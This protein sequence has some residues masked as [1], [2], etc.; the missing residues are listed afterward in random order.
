VGRSFSA[1]PEVVVRHAALWIN[2]HSGAG[3]YSCIKHFPGHG[4]SSADTHRGAVDV[5]GTWR[6]EE[7]LPYRALLSPDAVSSGLLSRP[8]RFVMTSHVFNGR[9]DRENPA[10]LSKLILTDLLRGEIGFD[11]LVVSDDIDMK[12]I[13]DNYAFGAALVKA[14]N[15]GVDIVC[16]S[17]NGD[18]FDEAIAEKAIAILYDAVLAGEIPPARIYESYARILKIKAALY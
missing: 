16:L 14:V 4:S 2:A 3:V 15:A 1:D 8:L 18:S 10:T 13:R 17:N 6:E 5:S 11:G 9:L 12:A 7:L